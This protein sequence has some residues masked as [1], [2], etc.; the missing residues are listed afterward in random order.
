MKDKKHTIAECR[1]MLRACVSM[2]DTLTLDW[3]NI[4]MSD[5]MYWRHLMY[6]RIAHLALTFPASIL[7]RHDYYQ[8][9]VSIYNE[10]NAQY[11]A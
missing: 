6:Q 9:I 5:Y 4:T 3:D 10:I 2:L 7:T 1:K 8:L 11:N